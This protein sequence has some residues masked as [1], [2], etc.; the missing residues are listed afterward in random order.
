MMGTDTVRRMLLRR[1]CFGEGTNF[2]VTAG[3]KTL[4]PV[5]GRFYTFRL[6]GQH[7]EVLEE[8]TAQGCTLELLDVGSKDCSCP[9]WGKQLPVRIRQLHSHWLC[10]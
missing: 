3:L 8:D 9:G 1:R 4:R 2:E 7:L 6:V 5:G 10:R